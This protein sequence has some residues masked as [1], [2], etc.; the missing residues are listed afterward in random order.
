MVPTGCNGTS[1][2]NRISAYSDRYR[3]RCRTA[4]IGG[5]HGV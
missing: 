5:G 4:R 2:A 1:H 3:Y